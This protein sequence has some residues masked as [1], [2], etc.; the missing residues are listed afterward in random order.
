MRKLFCFIVTCLMLFSFC[1][2]NTITAQSPATVSTL[3][4]TNTPKLSYFDQLWVKIDSG[5]I[6]LDRKPLGDISVIIDELPELEK[7]TEYIVTGTFLNDSYQDL[8]AFPDGT[9]VYGCTITS[10]KIHDVIQGD[11]K[12][13][14]IIK[15]GEEYAVSKDPESEFVCYEGNYLPSKSQTEY[16]FFLRKTPD[17]NKRFAGIYAPVQKEKGRYPYLNSTRSI[18]D[19]TNREMSLGTGESETYKSL[20]NAVAEKYM[21]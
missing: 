17:T 11:L 3:N 20:Y 6:K 1:F 12:S 4:Q 7:Y 14:D 16:L 13:G 2:T 5:N 15:I 9:V 10:F 8:Q 21:N 18:D 19:L